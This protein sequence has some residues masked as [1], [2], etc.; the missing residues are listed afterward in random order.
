MF[1]G[2][3]D[4]GKFMFQVLYFHTSNLEVQRDSSKKLSSSVQ[5]PV[6]TTLSPVAIETLTSYMPDSPQ[7][8]D[9]GI[10]GGVILQTSSSLVQSPVSPDSPMITLQPDPPPLTYQPPLNTMHVVSSILDDLGQYGGV[11]MNRPA[12]TNPPSSTSNIITSSTETSASSNTYQTP[13][14]EPTR[15]VTIGSSKPT[16]TDAIDPFDQYGGVVIRSI[17]P[18]V[19]GNPN[20]ISSIRPT[21]STYNVPGLE[22]TTSTRRSSGVDKTP[23]RPHT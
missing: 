4:I 14:V 10:F 19:E 17:T 2:S 3:A 13:S 1:S 12:P 20:N 15:I 18:S 23:V 16:N 6:T 21:E 8:G 7:A 22:R 9:I 5:A 11:I